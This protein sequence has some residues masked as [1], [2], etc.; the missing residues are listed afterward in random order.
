M[1]LVSIVVPIYNCKEYLEQC[2]Q[3]LVNQTL[4]D[5]EIILVDDGSTDGS[6]LICDELSKKDPR[7]VV[8]HQKNN[9]VSAARNSGIHIATGKYIGFSDADDISLE[10]KF[11]IQYKNAI[12]TGA[13]VSVIGMIVYYSDNKKQEVYG[14]GKKYFWTEKEKTLPLKYGLNK[15]VLTMSPYCMIV[16]S[17]L[18][19]QEL[20]QEGRHINEDRFF[21]FMIIAK[22]KSICYEDVCKY[23]YMQ[24][25]GSVAH[26]KFSKKF[27]DCTY[28]ADEME[29]YVISNVPELMEDAKLNSC[30]IKIM[31]LKYLLKDADAY[32]NFKSDK[33]KL[34]KEIMQYGFKYLSKNLKKIRLIDAII[35]CKFTWLY[36]QLIRIYQRYIKYL[37]KLEEIK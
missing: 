8:I 21:G 19:K 4:K 15:Q 13:E 28:F 3:S 24:R 6:D 33:D 7:I 11:E 12:E 29:K 26:S 14:T 16:K 22:A 1:I 18:C 20:F 37:S 34:I 35:M 23:Y 27:F 30:K 9:G 5:I 36:S 25:E 2:V 31:V 32:S 17:S 10:D